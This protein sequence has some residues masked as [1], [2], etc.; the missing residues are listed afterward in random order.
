V[1]EYDKVYA[2]RA[3]DPEKGEY[4]VRVQWLDTVDEDH[5]VNEIGFFGNQNTVCQPLTT[6]WGKTVERLKSRFTNWNAEG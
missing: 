2:A 1:L 6:K 5:A 3:A 4:F